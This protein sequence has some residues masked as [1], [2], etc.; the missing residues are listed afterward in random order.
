MP[1]MSKVGDAE[2]LADLISVYAED[3]IFFVEDQ[4][5]KDT[6]F[7]VQEWQKKV[8][9]QLVTDQRVIKICMSASAG[10]GKTALKSWVLLWFMLTQGDGDCNVRGAAM[11][12]T[13]ENLND[14][15]WAEVNLWLQKSELLKGMFEITSQGIYSRDHRKTWFVSTRSFG[16]T[17]KGDEQAAALSGIH[18][19][20]VLFLIDEAGEISPAVGK[21]ADQAAGGA[22]KIFILVSGN[23]TVETGLLYY[24]A[25]RDPQYKVHEIT[26]DPDDPD[27]TPLIDAE[28]ARQ[29]IEEDG[30]DDPWIMIYILGKF[31]P[32]GV[33]KLLSIE[34]VEAAMDRHYTPDV[35]KLYQKRLGVDAARFG[36]DPWVIF[37]RQ[38]RVAFRPRVVR[39]PRTEEMTRQVLKA[40]HKF[41][42]EVEYFDDT[43]GWAVGVIDALME[44]G[45]APVPVNFAS[46]KTMDAGMYNVRAE[47]YWNMAEWIKKGGALPRDPELLREL[48]APT[49][50]FKNGKMILESKDQIKKR[51]GH[52]LDRADA[53][54]LTFYD[55]ESLS[56]MRQGADTGKTDW[57]YNPIQ[58][59]DSK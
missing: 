36:D 37:P 13:R 16:K 57:D 2:V 51:I 20:S 9:R 45:Y 55:P 1:K 54:A 38:G 8:L 30:R 59:L 40:K 41:G 46:Q 27:R 19:K 34:E 52:S 49:Y 10:C 3:P 12:I 15:M 43:G 11:S 28:W 24:C 17:A 5:L 56:M 47:M 32:G 22:E 31:P 6:E 44:R 39:N 7:V 33:N 58:E 50:A 4:L 21:K 23:P 18:A 25:R 48:T 42:S 26:A 35:Y 53:L 29:K 14:N